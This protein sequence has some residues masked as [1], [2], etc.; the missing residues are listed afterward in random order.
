MDRTRNMRVGDDAMFIQQLDR[1]DGVILALDWSPDSKLIAVAGA[2]AK[3]NLYD[4]GTGKHVAG[5][6]GH[7]AGIYALAFSPDSST[8]ATGGFDGKIRLYRAS[9][10]SLLTSFIPVPLEQASGGGQ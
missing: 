8:L 4:A 10:C 2:S 7:D 5:C 9:D 6:S 1:Q 3:V